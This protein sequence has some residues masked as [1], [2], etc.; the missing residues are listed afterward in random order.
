[1][2][3]QT[4]PAAPQAQAPD[5]LY[6]EAEEDLRSAVR[7]LLAARADAPTVIAATESDTP[8]DQQL[9]ESLAG[10]IGAAG[11]LVPEEFGG[12]GREPP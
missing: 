8:Y 12:Q 9:W 4:G 1:M 3:T 6:S 7:A 10:G 5:L 2:S 11:L